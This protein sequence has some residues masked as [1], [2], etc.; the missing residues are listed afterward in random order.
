MP[1]AAFNE[2][3]TSAYLAEQ[4]KIAGY[5]V[6][7]GIGGTGVTG[8]L[9]SGK[10]GP[11][12]ALR[13][14]MDALEHTIEGK[15]VAIHSCG[16]DAHSAMVLTTAMEIARRGLKA[17]ALK[18][19]FQPA[20]EVLTGALR[21][22]E[23]GAVA[24]V[25]VLI[26]MHLRPI[27]EAKKGEATPA[28]YHGA[29]YVLEGYIKGRAAHGARPHLGINVIDAAA[30]V[31]CGINAIRMNPS[32]PCSA[33]VTKLQAGGTALNVIPDSAYIAIDLRS[34]DNNLMEELI[35]RVIRAVEAGAAT[36]GAEAT[37]KVKGG[38][39]AAEYSSEI[40]EVA[41]QAIAD[42]LGPQALLQ[43]IVTPGGEDFHHFIRNKPSLKVGYVGLGCDLTPGLHHPD[44]KFD[45]ASMENGVKILLHMVNNLIGIKQ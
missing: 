14:D 30:A 39:P 37:V 32:V 42:V 8:K 7:I 1:E 33:K 12:L 6:R 26:G 40:I 22:I 13:A 2:H 27:Q 5:A 9:E 21:M 38:V 45:K 4:L 29:S 28:L 18:I 31:I 25:D 35:T 34:Q 16:H 15:D 44:M 3:R 41:K 20:E 24:D 19:I 36:V 17:G 23:D 43:P 11:V 10:P